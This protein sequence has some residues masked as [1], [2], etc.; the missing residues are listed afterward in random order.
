MFISALYTHTHTLTSRTEQDSNRRKSKYKVES[1]RDHIVS[2]SI[3]NQTT[4]I[5]FVCST[6]IK[7]FIM[8]KVFARSLFLIEDIEQANRKEKDHRAGKNREE[9]VAPFFSIALS[10]SHAL[11]NSVDK[12]KKFV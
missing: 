12:S 7:S 4:T 1:I 8:T 3:S 2:F 5:V 9:K 11:P 10:L 6:T